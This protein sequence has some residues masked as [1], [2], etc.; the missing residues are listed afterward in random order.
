MT[1][2][3][4]KC[5]AEFDRGPGPPTAIGALCPRCFSLY[6]L[7]RVNERLKLRRAYR[8]RQLPVNPWPPHETTG[9]HAK[10]RC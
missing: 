1:A 4:A 2:N 9:L 8:R 6:A 10:P 5:G 3:C 7:A